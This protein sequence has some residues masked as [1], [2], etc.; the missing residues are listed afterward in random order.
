MIASITRTDGGWFV[1]LER[2]E[3]GT[4]IDTWEVGRLVYQGKETGKKLKDVSSAVIEKIGDMA[5]VSLVQDNRVF[6]IYDCTEIYV[7]LSTYA[8]LK[9]I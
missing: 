4:P 3:A 6:D 5:R 1:H 8:Q 7:G 9:E 2:R